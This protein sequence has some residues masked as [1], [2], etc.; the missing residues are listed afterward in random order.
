MV[1][2][3][4]FDM[5]GLIFDTER[6]STKGWLKCGEILNIDLDND[7]INSFKGTPREYSCNLF[8]E[9]FGEDFDYENARAIRTKYINDYVTE[10]GIPVKKGL[11]KLLDFLKESN[12]PCAVA[13]STRKEMAE[14]YF[15]MANIK[16]YFSAFVYGNMV[17][18]GKP[19]P[20]IFLKASEMLGVNISECIVLEDSP[21]GIKAGF[22]AGSKVVCVP[23]MIPL[24]NDILGRVSYCVSNLSFVIDIIKKLM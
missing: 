21:A 12:I 8:K 19:E 18:R 13:T 5:D 23:D 22:L 17:K 20:D 15:E 7:F 1:K 14:K 11:Y 24:D 4:I 10:N 2:G 3:V 9:K 16:G 6:L